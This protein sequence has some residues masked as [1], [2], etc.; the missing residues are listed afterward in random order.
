[1]PTRRKAESGLWPLLLALWLPPT[2]AA[3]PAVA[4]P[5]G[6]P[7]LP[8][9]A[10]RQGQEAPAPSLPRPNAAMRPTAAAPRR[11]EGEEE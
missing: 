4:S 6:A 7:V 2:V 10:G 9:A 1:M 5:A 8:E 11:R 3:P